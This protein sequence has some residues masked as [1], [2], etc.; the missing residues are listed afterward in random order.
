MS[1]Q[2]EKAVRAWL[3]CARESAAKATHERSAG[4]NMQADALLLIALSAA[5]TATDECRR[6]ATELGAQL[7]LRRPGFGAAKMARRE[8]GIGQ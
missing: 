7:E 2:S 5:E 8:G 6:Y 1:D 3:Q 4:N